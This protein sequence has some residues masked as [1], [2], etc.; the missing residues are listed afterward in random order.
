MATF[1]LSTEIARAYGHAARLLR[2]GATLRDRGHDVAIAYLQQRLG[3]RE[4][5][6]H[7]VALFDR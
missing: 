4:R 5:P 3:E 7:R 6:R 2:V 1:L